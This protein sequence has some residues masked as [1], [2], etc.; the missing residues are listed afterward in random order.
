MQFVK[1]I[2]I[3]HDEIKMTATVHTEMEQCEQCWMID[4]ESGPQQ[5]FMK[6]VSGPI[7]YQQF[8]ERNGMF[9]YV[10]GRYVQSL[11]SIKPLE[12]YSKYVSDNNS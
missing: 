6:F 4:I 11:R 3:D 12:T 8:I 10:F 7:K 1:I 9:E 5:L 2:K